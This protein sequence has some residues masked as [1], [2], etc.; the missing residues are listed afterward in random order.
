MNTE[1][2]TAHDAFVPDDFKVRIRNYGD[3]VAIFS[4]G[5][6]DRFIRVNISP[7]DWSRLVANTAVSEA[8]P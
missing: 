8:T 5:P 6:S 2:T 3:H 1:E 4:F 7:E